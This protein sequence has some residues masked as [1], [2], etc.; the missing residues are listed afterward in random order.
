MQL[1]I[2]AVLISLLA[3]AAA[4]LARRRRLKERREAEW[5]AAHP[6][7]SHE[8]EPAW[9]AQPAAAAPAEA[10]AFAWGARDERKMSR[11]ERARLGPTPDN[12][13]LS[14]KKR[15]KRAAFFDQRDREMA[16]GNAVPVDS[17]A[18]IPE[19]MVQPDHGESAATMRER[20]LEPA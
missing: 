14:L 11:V 19:S 13:S 15:L 20:E 1:T 5:E 3:L 4:L 7:E 12:P 9:H 10:S 16:A 6:V 18:G 2:G 8:P 17:T